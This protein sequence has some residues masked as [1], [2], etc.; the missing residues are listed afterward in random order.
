[1]LSQEKGLKR[2]RR[3]VVLSI[4]LVLSSLMMVLSG[5]SFIKSPERLPLTVL[6]FFQSGISGITKGISH[7]VNSISELRELRHQYNQAMNKIS[8]YKGIRRNYVDLLNEN[9]RLRTQLEFSKKLQIENIPAEIIGRDPENLFNTITLNKGSH[10]GV[11]PNM[12][13]IAFQNGLYG[14]VGKTVQTS[15]NS[16]LV[17]PLYDQNSYISARLQLSRY[18]G[19]V[20][21]LGAA[22]DALRMQY[23]KKSARPEINQGDLVVTSGLGSVYPSDVYIGRVKKLF[24]REYET[25]LEIDIEPVIDFTQLEYVYVMSIEEA[26]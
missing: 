1:M 26:Q 22:S 25:S 15:F 19:L 7:S 17:Q 10:H 5:S 14:L 2:Y 21:G 9:K 3:S 18:Q 13:V 8:E 11:E 6:S 23:V 24:S 16:S 4:L 20:S 12:A